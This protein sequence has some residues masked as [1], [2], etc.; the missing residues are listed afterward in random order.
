MVLILQRM[1]F[2]TENAN[3][4]NAWPGYNFHSIRPT[5]YTL[6]IV[7][8]FVNTD[9]LTHMLSY[10]IIICVRDHWPRLG[11]VFSCDVTQSSVVITFTTLC[12]HPDFIQSLRRRRQPHPRQ[13][14][15]VLL[16]TFETPLNSDCSL[17]YKLWLWL[18]YEVRHAVYISCFFYSS[19]DMIVGYMA[20]AVCEVSGCGALYALVSINRNTFP[21]IL[22]RVKI[23]NRLQ[24]SMFR[25]SILK[26]GDSKSSS[27]IK[28]IFGLL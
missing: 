12:Y 23:L 16:W 17:C 4:C 5:D 14:C 22:V 26:W 8:Q 6:Q 28:S 11:H 9:E 21:N 20:D 3:S 15:L 18:W 25:I 13:M 7:Y 27:Y 24:T 10:V 19:V 2:R 1:F